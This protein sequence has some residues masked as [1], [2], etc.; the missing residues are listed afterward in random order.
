MR[1][2]EDLQEAG[3]RV[4]K[5]GT[6]VKIRGYRVDGEEERSSR[7]QRGRVTGIYKHIFTV[8]IK[9]RQE[10]FRWNQLLGNECTQVRLV[11]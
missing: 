10:S 8:D 5:I 4:L 11:K 7:E 2:A 6:K 3:K 9:G 1:K